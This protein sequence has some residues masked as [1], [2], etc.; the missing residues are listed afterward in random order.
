M[1]VTVGELGKS[2]TL[3]GS[4]F[5]VLWG[6]E[7]PQQREFGG[8]QHSARHTVGIGADH[9]LNCFPPSGRTGCKGR[10]TLRGLQALEALY[11][12][13]TRFSSHRGLCIWLPDFF[14]NP[15]QCQVSRLWSDFSSHS[16]WALVWLCASKHEAVLPIHGLCLLCLHACPPLALGALLGSLPAQNS[17]PSMG[18]GPHTGTIKAPKKEGSSL[19]QP[20][21]GSRGALSSPSSR[22]DRVSKVSRALAPIPPRRLPPKKE[23]EEQEEEG[24]VSGGLFL[25]CSGGKTLGR[26]WG[27]VTVGLHPQL[28]LSPTPSLPLGGQGHSRASGGSPC[29]HQVSLRQSLGF[30]IW[31]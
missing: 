14:P 4:Y 20:A 31:F 21:H 16:L 28:P 8:C 29:H 10:F 2:L 30:A 11:S 1:K 27:G 13:P 22:R 17:K 12:L 15:L 26:T 5:P 23:E 6:L 9:C 24:T 3:S 19:G 7:R 25:G 18:S